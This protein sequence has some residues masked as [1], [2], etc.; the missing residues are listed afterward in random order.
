LVQRL[1]VARIMRTVL[2]VQISANGRYAHQVW[3]LNVPV[4]VK[5]WIR[6]YA[7]SVTVPPVALSRAVPFG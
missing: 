4:V 3:K 7:F 2:L 5:V 6:Q 1:L